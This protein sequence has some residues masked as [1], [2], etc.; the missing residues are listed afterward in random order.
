MDARS[1]SLVDASFWS[2]LQQQM[3]L[4][5]GAQ[6]FPRPAVEERRGREGPPA[7]SERG[8]E[9]V[10][11]FGA[12]LGAFL[13]RWGLQGK[14]EAG[15]PGASG[16]PQREVGRPRSQEAAWRRM[17]ECLKRRKKTPAAA[18]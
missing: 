13:W 7:A 4:S 14:K 6:V 5:Q 17:D 11:V 1:Q 18:K 10:E 9:S 3:N 16:I 15:A 2:R 8:E 12:S